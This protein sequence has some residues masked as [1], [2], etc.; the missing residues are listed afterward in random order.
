[1]SSSSD[2]P[3][4]MAANGSRAP[5]SRSETSMLMAVGPVTRMS[6]TPYWSSQPGLRSR[7]RLTSAAVDRGR[8]TG[9]RDHLHQRG[10]P[11]LVGR[12]LGDV[13]DAGHFADAS[14]RSS[15]VPRV[16]LVMTP[17]VSGERRVVALAEGAVIAS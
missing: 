14:A 6:V 9:S 1:M 10:V 12:G 16:V 2:S 15:T 8:L 3:M 4:T 17:P 5:A 13:H 11:A 7:S